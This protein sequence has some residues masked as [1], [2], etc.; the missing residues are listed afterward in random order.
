MPIEIVR[1]GNVE[2]KDTVKFDK[3]GR[4]VIG[5][6]TYVGHEVY[7]CTH[8]HPVKDYLRWRQMPSEPVTLEIG[9]WVFIGYR[10]IILPQ[11]GKI[12][13]GAIIGAGAV[14]TRE[15]PPW[16][17]VAGNPAEIIGRREPR[18]VG[19]LRTL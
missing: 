1:K 16:A 13:T 9:E 18:D 5:E 7:I 14:V 15:V 2:I 17:I 8:I 4:V 3:R 11:V 10:A 12:G 6:G 19:T